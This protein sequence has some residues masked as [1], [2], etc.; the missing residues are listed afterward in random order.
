VDVLDESAIEQHLRS[1][2]EQAG[3][4]DISFNAVGL[5]DED[6]LGDFLMDTSAE[7]FMRPIAYFATS[8]LPDAR[9]AH[10]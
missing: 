8:V 4:V 2:V 7:R 10:R 3:R 1:V 5:P 6:H 9:L